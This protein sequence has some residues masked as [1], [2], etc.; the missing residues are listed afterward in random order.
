VIVTGVLI[1]TMSNRLHLILGKF[2]DVFGIECNVL[3]S[4]LLSFSATWRVAHVLDSIHKLQH[5]YI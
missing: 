2:T 4:P 5:S 3:F 1:P